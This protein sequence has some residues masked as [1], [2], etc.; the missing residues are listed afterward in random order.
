MVIDSISGTRLTWNFLSE[1]MIKVY[2]VLL[3]RWLFVFVVKSSSYV[4]LFM[5]KW[6]AACQ[7]SMSLTISWSLSKFMFIAS[8]MPSNHLILWHPLFLLSSIFPSIRDFS[9]EL[10]VHIRGQKYWSFS[11]SL[12][13]KYIQGWSPLRLTGLIS[14]LLSKGLSGVFYSITVQKHQIFGVLPSLSFSSHNCTWPLGRPYP[15]QYG[16]LLAD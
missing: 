2:F 1:I 8:V 10:S 9:N 4:Q 3:M 6:T 11:I 12:S 13:S 14:L 7:A 15:W 16:P 5:T